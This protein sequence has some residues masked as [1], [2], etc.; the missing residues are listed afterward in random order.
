MLKAGALPPGWV[1]KNHALAIGAAAARGVWLLFTDADTFH[2]PGST[3]RA[4]RDAVDR[5]AV[6]VSYSPEQEMET[7]WERALIPVVYCCLAQNFSYASVNDAQS[8]TAAANGQFL[9]IPH[10][11]Y[12]A[13]GGYSSIAGE[14]LDDVALAQRVKGA[15]YRIYFTAPIGVVR[16]RMYRSFSAMWQGWTKNLYLLL[17]G[18]PGHLLREAFLATAVPAV[19]L[20]AVLYYSAKGRLMYPFVGLL[21][22]Y[23]AGLH[24]RYAGQLY[25]NLLPISLIKYYVPGMCLYYA[26]LIASWWK[27]TRGGVTWKGRTYAARTSVQDERREPRNLLEIR[28]R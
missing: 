2:L 22:L 21:A 5:N 19:L 6:L 26:A 7:F 27:T 13:V 25:K 18:T 20:A 11:V 9:L 28:R 15:G 24:A 10:D 16:T 4:L 8:P 17:G 3:A 1:G 12:R 14:L 23:L